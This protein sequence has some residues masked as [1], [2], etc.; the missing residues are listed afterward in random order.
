MNVTGGTY[1]GFPVMAKAQSWW[2]GGVI[3]QIYPRSF[4]DTNGDGIGD[5]PGIRSRL[6]YVAALGVDAVWISPFFASP[7]KDFGYDIS[8][9]RDVDP[10]FGSL[11]DFR[12]LVDKARELGLRIIIDQVLS[13]S[14]D[15]HPWF[16]ESRQSR[17]NAKADWYVWAD[18]GADGTPPNNW[19]SIFGGSAWTWDSRRRQYYLHNFLDSQPDLNFHNPAVRK[20]QLDNLRFWLDLGVDG[21][22]LDVVNNYFH[23]QGLEN[24]PPAGPGNP[25]PFG[26]TRDNPYAY[27]RHIHDVTRPENLDFLRDIRRLVDEYDGT[28]TV[29]EIT[30][31][32]PVATLADYTSGG[33]KLHMAYTFSLLTP[34]ASAANVRRIIESVESRIGDGWPC[35]ALSN[36]DVKRVVS[37]WSE[38]AEDERLARTAIALAGA[39]RGTICLYQGDELGLTEANV[40]YDRITDPFGLPF[41]PE[42]KGRDGCRTPMVWTSDPERFG[43]FSTVEPWLPVDERQLDSAVNLQEQ[44]EDSTLKA[45]RQFLDWRKHQPALRDGGIELC[46]TGDMLC[47]IRRSADQGILVAV[48]LTARELRGRAPAGPGKVL[49]GHGFEGRIEG[50]DIVLPPYQALFADVT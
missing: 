44:R 46:E 19:L 45:V 24:N 50:R 30:G 22:R 32:D 33:D 2:R 14:S 38:G 40:P 15:R 4:M 18:P 17:D 25:L 20:A 7:M 41:W 27:Q 23:S 47:W 29:G 13:H 11:D 12:A 28:T 43:G 5:L 6:E 37:R 42:Y 35:W 36:H 26:L 39:M 9:Y 16:E 48:N 1:R 21:F 3:Y 34:D 8:D 31:D 49:T 10:I